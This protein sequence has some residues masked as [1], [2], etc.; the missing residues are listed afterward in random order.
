MIRAKIRKIL[1]PMAAALTA[2]AL[3][4]PASAEADLSGFAEALTA[5]ES[6]NVR[7]YAAV[8][9]QAT[10]GNISCRPERPIFVSQ[11][12]VDSRITVKGQDTAATAITCVDLMLSSNANISGELRIEYLRAGGRA[13]NPADWELAP[14]GRAPIAGRMISGVGTALGVADVVYPANHESAGRPH[15]ACVRTFAPNDLP[16]LCTVSPNVDTRASA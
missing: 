14:N 15:R 2:L 3:A 16:D 10:S 1:V 12:E 6:A 7:H 9:A 4:V 13:T 8:A 5:T 11:P